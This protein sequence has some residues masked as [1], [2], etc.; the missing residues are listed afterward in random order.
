MRRIRVQTEGLADRQL[1]RV[2]TIGDALQ[3]WLPDLNYLVKISSS[4]DASQVARISAS[5]VTNL[6]PYLAEDSCG[7]ALEGRYV[8]LIDGEFEP[9]DIV[10][11][12]AGTEFAQVLYRH[13]DM[14]HAIFLTN[15]CNSYCLMCS[16]PPTRHDDSWLVSEALQLA[17]YIKRSPSALGFSGGEPLLLGRSLR[18]VLDA[19]RFHHPDTLLEV[20]TNGRLLA[21][22]KL[23][24]ELLMG[25]DERI[26]WLV[27]LYG[28]AEFI[29]DFVVQS[30]GAFEETLAAILNLQ[31]YAQPI[32][33]RIVLIEPVLK[34]L[35][36]LC[37]FI[38]RSLP[39][40][41][42][43]ALMGCEPIG[44][45]LANRDVCEVDLLN[46]QDEIVASAAILR[47]GRVP[48]VFMNTPL[49]ALPE[50]LWRDVS[51]SISDWK[52][53]FGPECQVCSV[54]SDCP[55]LFAWYERGWTP[56]AIKP[57][58]RGVTQ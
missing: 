51:R 49:C 29:H 27:P 5:G 35:P 37:G 17:R 56:T 38:A 41:Q 50:G 43:V 54:K 32:Q 45:A 53:V 13:S 48:Y 31:Q 7:T 14:H 26:R 8:L 25:S 36:A 55:G 11:L 4:E 9:D 30:P 39:F 21:S 58:L 1:Y 22:Q 20:L 34:V 44:F 15:R 46:W 42:H 10:A 47:R 57:I 16:Q 3:D 33:L 52:Q 24:A 19:F 6:L 2:S 12:T 40:V 28:H 23:A 18:D